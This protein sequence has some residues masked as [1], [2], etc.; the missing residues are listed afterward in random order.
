MC[1]TPLASWGPEE[2]ML[3][4]EMRP[5]ESRMGP[6]N[7]GRVEPQ[8]EFSCCTEMIFIVP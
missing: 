1:K 7:M 5:D 2:C 4:E 6:L 3:Y 8:A